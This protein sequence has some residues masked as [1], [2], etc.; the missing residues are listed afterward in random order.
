MDQLA[1]IYRE[2]SGALYENLDLGLGL[3]L[4]GPGTSNSSYQLPDSVVPEQD[5]ESDLD[6]E[7][8]HYGY[9]DDNQETDEDEETPRDA[10]APPTTVDEW[11]D[12]PMPPTFPT[13]PPANVEPCTSIPGPSQPLPFDASAFDFFSQFFTEEIFHLMA[14]ETNRYA[15]QR[16]VSAGKTDKYWKPVTVADIKV[17]L[18][19]NV[20]MGIHSLPEYSMYWSTDDRLRVSGIADVMGKNRY[21]KVHQ[22][23]HLSDSTL[24]VPRG[25]PGYDPL[26]KVRHL[27]NHFRTTSK[28]LYT[29]CTAL[30]ID[31]AMIA[32]TGRLQFKQY[33]KAKP[34][35][36]GIKVWCIADPS[37]GYMLDVDVY[38]GKS[39]TPMPDGL[40][41]HVVMKMAEDYLDKH[42][43]LYFDNYFA[44]VK[45]AEDL[46]QRSTYSCSTIRAGR[47]G[48]PKEFKNLKKMRPGEI[49]MKTKGPLVATVWNDKRK[50]SILS[51]NAPAAITTAERRIR[52]G[53]HTINIP[54]SVLDY[55]SH[56]FGVD[57]ADQLRSYYAVGR[58]GVK[59]WRYVFWFIVQI[60]L[61]NSWNLFKAA[62]RPHPSNSRLFAQLKFRLDVCYA[63]VAG[64]VSKG[65]RKVSLDIASAGLG[66]SL[67]SDHQVTRQLGRKRV[68]R[69]CSKVGNKTNN[70]K[71]SESV[72]G[73]SICKVNLHKGQCFASFHRE[74]AN[75]QAH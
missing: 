47:R 71:T 21:E 49:R 44:S 40:G 52:G 18:A 67:S 58:S 9:Q 4:L 2:A 74:L 60:S 53:K 10:T 63:L 13:P 23:F 30:S 57:L 61:V 36:W 32:Y 8:Y 48:W 17:Y 64:N 20:L 51:T 65:K 72:W 12:L 22:Y 25:Q 75:V 42:H 54:A 59:W 69:W 6:E 31:E 28:S 24:A 14:Q 3:D 16:Q 1:T 41:H 7:V 19:I 66:S 39:T 11:V 43:Q 26:Y 27:I 62:N 5:A 34:T 15:E 37:N 29:P 70:G 73:C 45:L 68:C 46:L 35:P 33:I 56:M 50:V 55:N 38:T